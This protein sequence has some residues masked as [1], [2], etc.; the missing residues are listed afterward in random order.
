MASL[1]RACCN[2]SCQMCGAGELL[3][4]SSCV[5]PLGSQEQLIC[6]AGELHDPGC[7]SAAQQLSHVAERA[8]GTSEAQAS[9]TVIDHDWLKPDSGSCT[10]FNND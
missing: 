3:S 2:V 7:L 4:D 5:W 9:I 10:T 8:V 1:H 6:M